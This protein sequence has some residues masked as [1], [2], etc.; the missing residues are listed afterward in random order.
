M[1]DKTLSLDSTNEQI[2][3]NYV[4]KDYDI[5]REM[6]HEYRSNGLWDSEIKAFMDASTLKSLFFHED[7]VFIAVDLIANKVSKQIMRVVEVKEKNGKRIIEPADD[8]ILNDLLEQPNEQ[9]GYSEWMYNQTSELILMGN[10]MMWASK[11]SGQMILLPTENI[12]MSFNNKQQLES[13]DVRN[14]QSLTKQALMR[15]KPKEIVH[16][17]RA[18]P[19]SIWYG[20]SPFIPGR[21]SILFSRYSQDYLNGF[22]L[23]NAL[24]GFSLQL[25]KHVNEDIALR[26]LR[27]F[28]QA[29][30]GRKSQ[31]RTLL[32]PKGVT[33]APINHSIADQNLIDLIDKNRETII[34]I[35]KIPKHELSLAKTGSLGSEEYKQS[36]KNFWESTIIPT[37]RIIEGQ[38]NKHFSEELGDGFRFKFDLNDV[39]ILKEDMLYKADLAEKMLLTHTL[40]EVRSTVYDDEPLEGGD[41]LPGNQSSPVS[42]FQNKHKKKCKKLKINL[43]M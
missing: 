11:G 21:K 16:M 40:N 14:E 39:A 4:S 9:Q 34:N 1:E 32:I 15:F 5:V 41:K 12:S 18:N 13:Y 10:A 8:H 6:D 19:A 42:K 35:L 43:W 28:E 23:R 2:Y 3:S 27:T 7:W 37:M 25:D 26:M 17:K 31:R 38:Y 29:Y 36:L 22:Y 33:A 24:P 20:L 30:S